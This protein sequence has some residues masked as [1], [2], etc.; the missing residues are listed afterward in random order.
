MSQEN[1]DLVR[2]RYEAFA[3]Q[4]IPGVLEPFDANVEWT[5]PDTLPSGGTYHGPDGVGGFFATLP[6]TWAELSVGPEEYLDAGDTVVVLGTHRMRGHNG[7][8]GEAGF[9]HIWDISNGKVV[10]FREIADTAKLLPSLEKQ[11]A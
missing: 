7:V 5:A 10:R 2:G 1:V 4:D 9:A 8:D 11:T 6:D 3:R